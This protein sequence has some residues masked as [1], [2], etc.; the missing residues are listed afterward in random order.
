MKTHIFFSLQM[1]V[2]G[3]CLFCAQLS[4]AGDKP[5]VEIKQGDLRYVLEISGNCESVTIETPADPQKCSKVMH[6]AHYVSGVQKRIFEHNEVILAFVGNEQIQVNTVGDLTQNVIS[7]EVKSPTGLPIYKTVNGRCIRKKSFANE[8]TLTECSAV[9]AQLGRLRLERF[10][11]AT[12]Q[13][14]WD[15]FC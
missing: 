3:A 12:L 2:C 14:H 4:F 8:A 13:V 5:A 9:T 11:T 7:L 15:D 10:P 6:I 1:L